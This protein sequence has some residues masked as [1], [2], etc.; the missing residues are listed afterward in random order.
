MLDDSYS[1]Y[2][3]QKNE[4]NEPESNITLRIPTKLRN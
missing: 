4:I 2:E 3:Q 1:D